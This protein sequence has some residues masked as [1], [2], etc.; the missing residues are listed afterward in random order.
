MKKLNDDITLIKTTGYVYYIKWASTLMVLIAV[1]CRSVDEIPKIYDVVF[2]LF[3]TF[4]W[5][6]VG[7]A[8][9]DRALIVLNAVIVFM[10]ATSVMRYIA[11]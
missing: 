8:W 9:K 4:G 6:Y 3:G 11:S 5:L 10:L 7:L 1:A 2:S